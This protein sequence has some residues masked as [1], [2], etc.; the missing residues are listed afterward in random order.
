MKIKLLCLVTFLIA[1]IS[2]A[3]CD[4]T[5][6]LT[7]NFGSEWD[8]GANLTANAGVDITLNGTTT[9]YLV[10][11]PSAIPNTPVVE[12]YTISVNDGDA[13]DI[14]YRATFFPGDAGFRFL[15]SEGI[16]VYA[17]PF[18]Q[19]SMMD[20]YVDTATCP[21][22][23]AVT[24]LTTNTVTATSA[25]IGWTATGTEIAWEVEYGPVGFTPGAG[26]TDNA[27][28]NPW[29][30]D[31]LM[32]S[33]AYDVYVRADCGMGDISSNQGPI[34]FTT[35][36]SCP[37]PSN[38]DSIAESAFEIQFTWDANGNSSINNQVNYDVSPFVQ[39]P[40]TGQFANGNFGNFALIDNLMSATTYDFY[41]R[42]DCGMGD[43]SLWQGPYTATTE[44]S[45]PEVTGIQADVITDNSLDVSWTAG[46]AET[47][48][49]VEYAPAGI[50]TAPF[51]TLPQGTRINGLST[52][53]TPITGLTDATVYD[54][55]VRAFC[56][57]M[58]PDY[59]APT[60]LTVTTLCLE[61][62]P[63]SSAP[64]LQDFESF[65]ASLGFTEELCWTGAAVD[66]YDWNLDDNGGTPSTGTGPNAAFSGTNYFYTEAS[67]AT[68]GTSIATLTG[69][70]F[71]LSGLTNPSVQFYYHMFGGQI[72]DLILEVDDFSG[73]GWTGVS[74]ISGAQQTAQVD[75]WLLQIVSL[76]AYAGQTVRI[77]F[78]AIS[79]GS[80]EGDIA[81]DDFSVGELPACPDPSLLAVDATS[82]STAD[83]SWSEN[84]LA[85]SWE[86]EVQPTGVLQGTL[87]AAYENLT[88]TNPET[89][90]GLTPQTTYDYYVRSNCGV[91]GF[92][93]WAGP[94]TFTTQCDAAVA[95]YV[96]D[97]ENGFTPITTNFPGIGDAFDREN[98]YSATN[99]SY[100]WAIAS[101]AFTGTAG[102]GPDPSI[103]TG[104]YFYAE[105]NGTDGAV[106]DLNTPLFDSNA[107][108]VPSVSF[109]Y[110][111]VGA[112]IG[113]LEIIV[114]VAGIDNVV[115]TLTGAQQGAVTDPY[116]N[117]NIPLTAYAGQ[118]FQIV[119][120]A[121]R[122]NGTASDIAVDNIVIDEAPSCAAPRSLTASSVTDV[123]AILGWTNGNTETL[124][125]IELVLAGSTPT[126]T[127]TQA[128][129]TTNPYDALNLSSGTNYEFYLRA[130]CAVGDESLWTGPIVFTTLP[131]CGDTI[132]DT[133][134]AN[135]QYT[136]GESYTI[137]YLPQNAGDVVTLNFTAVDLE[138][139][140]DTLQIFDG[141]DNTAT[142]FS[143][144]LEAPDL[145][146]AT[147]A[148][149]AITLTFS[150][151]GSVTRDGWIAQ[152]ICAAPP[153]CLEVTSLAATNSTIDG[154]ELSWVTGGSG[155]S[156]W[157][158]EIVIAG[159]TPTG[160]PTNT[161]TSNP[162]AVT[163]LASSTAYDFYVRANCG[164]G[165]GTSLYTGPFQFDTLC[166]DLIAPFT[167]SFNVLNSDP[168]CWTQSATTGGP[169]STNG[170]GGFNTVECS[171][172]ASDRTGNSG[173]FA[174]LDFSGTDTAVILETPQID[175]SALTVP[176]VELYH[177]MCTTGYA[178]GNELY[179]EAIDGAGIW[180]QVALINT[181]DALWSKYGYDLSSFVYNTSFVQLRFR[182]ESGG[183]GDDYW[184]DMAIDD[185]SVIE[186]P[187]CLSPSFLEVDVV[188]SSA[189]SFSWTENNGTPATEWTIEYAETGVITVPGTSQGT[190]VDPATNPQA[191]TGLTPDTVYQYYVRANCSISD[192]SVYEG[193]FTF[194]TRCVP[195][196][197]V[198]TTDFESD[199]LDG[200]NNCDG[201]IINGG[202][203]ALVEVE[204]LISNTGTQHLYL[205]AGST[206]G[207]DV[208]YILPEFSDLSS[209]KRV[210][211]SVYDRDNG[212][213]E[214]GTMTDP[215]DASTFN[216]VA[217]FTD[218]DLA[219]DVYE[220][221]IVYFSSLTSTA[222]FIAFK[223][224]PAGTFDALYLDDIT[225]ELS[226]S[227]QEPT[228]LTFA[229]VGSSAFDFAWTN[230]SIATE[231]L[232]EYRETG[233][234][235]FTVVAPNP[236][237]TIVTISGLLS[238]TEYEVCVTAICDS[239]TNVVSTQSCSSVTTSQ[240]Y[241]G[242]DLFLDSGGATGQY[243]SNENITY[244]IC[245]DNAGDTVYVNFTMNQMEGFGAFCYDGLT[246]Y[247]GPDT[248]FPTINTPA[249]G[250]E[251]CWDGTSGTGDLTLETL[252]G[253]TASGCLTFVWSSDGS[254]TRDGWSANVT[255]AP[256]PS[257]PAPTALTAS[258]I[259]E[260]SSVLAW[261]ETGTAS[262]WQV[263]V[264]PIGIDQ[265]TT[266]S[267]IF[268]D[269]IATNPVTA[270]GLSASTSY[271]YF[272][273][274]DC[275]SGNFSAWVGPF[276]FTTSCAVVTG[277][278]YT[279]DFTNNVPNQ[280]WD[281]AGSGEI[282]DG[283]LTRGA[284]DWK[285]N[286]S[287]E[288]VSGTA[289]PSNVINLW[290]SV[291][292]EW[293]I[294]EVYDMTGTSNDLLTVEVAVT[295]YLF[296]GASTAADTAVMGSDDQ[297]DLLITTDSGVTWTSLTTW[298]AANQPATVGTSFSIDLS[299]YSGV[300]Q[301]AFLASDGTVDDTEDYDFHVGL[302][303]IDGTAGSNDMDSFEFNYYPNP[304]NSLVNFNGQQVIDGITVRNLLGQQLLVAKPNATSTSI[305]LSSFP[306]GLYLI[307]VASGEQSR[308]VK[309]LRN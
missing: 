254:I 122:G 107:L 304:T 168:T 70:Q 102:T 6:E 192:Q 281:E 226:P 202:N 104:N 243:A 27:I 247:D 181:G 36:E 99:S 308:V 151:D 7:D 278:P 128:A 154:A 294:S 193:P 188:T 137:T 94:F 20:I 194:S 283:P 142:A 199:P 17:S 180:Q 51:S 152:Y 244:N 90:T 64:Y 186:A 299:S 68:A 53:S 266:A 80:Y 22:C 120:R 157:D 245:P 130:V 147:N 288:N 8:S 216:A 257:C 5:L 83:L 86:V 33:T 155:E 84:G 113:S 133:G 184:G 21:T 127:P 309:V 275:G 272:V 210:R 162:Y 271:D 262:L 116:I 42:Y 23:F 87:G 198:Y 92:S 163:G 224:N 47:A 195:L 276:T 25:D 221:K 112:N 39:S 172:A 302:F 298:N 4:Y 146:R 179:I 103:T 79:G 170:G 93:S 144:D 31:G 293:L 69:P 28:S 105:G 15:D 124:W 251:W 3:Q 10:V 71:N 258:Q 191:I 58:L 233:T 95:P 61:F 295:D 78:R 81:L 260:T 82:D 134:G 9:T 241:C 300:V 239:A 110:H 121:T 30:I 270:T 91:D 166:D 282:A 222:G 16:E 249:G 178:P 49:E 218:S 114:R 268:E 111:M 217:T 252:I 255:C 201:S 106:A 236:T 289:V 18:S 231:Y 46:G 41:V 89:A 140:C 277:F 37:S 38:F 182:A 291:D 52:P 50:I 135:G 219:D 242:G 213:L 101:G 158:I 126:G 167:E 253:S 183:S 117:M 98:C 159:T 148:A 269:M 119:F 200:L 227:C 259:A 196:T 62:T 13:L 45:C 176:Y 75:D 150:S 228:Q 12:N 285:A 109:D 65:P 248:T 24:Q 235:A 256:P 215:T 66:S 264:Q 153:T 297:V 145:F 267:I 136:N 54:V 29:N 165:L 156:A 229:S 169:W 108:T 1:S 72:G 160:T 197:A 100:F 206:V 149:G 175:V 161:A 234:T 97:F 40:G 190:V 301:F 35:T 44:I 280:C 177:W 209:D 205:Y 261:M 273:R 74:T 59:S 290:Q 32:S 250:T 34:S 220:E 292:R 208:I 238:S 48:W 189:A 225:Y 305:D 73:S 60:Q 141:L 118:T 14:D 55:F 115:G 123:S 96:E 2:S 240:D 67:G 143:T 284:S 131:S 274:S 265:G 306:S 207:A 287:Y 26:T 56:D 19:G 138:S 164:G 43:F 230:N 63:T 237:S 171:T 296:T 76:D 212:G 129:V 203:G 223:F 279:T 132:Y 187:S 88:S 246:I 204:D 77:R 173:S 307:E 232:V 185:L 214:V 57:P 85:T 125:D 263:E 303:V 11:N 174:W 139:C 286:R 211:F